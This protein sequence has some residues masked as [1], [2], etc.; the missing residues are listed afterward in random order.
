MAMPDMLFF[1]E[2][3]ENDNVL[4]IIA[5]GDTYESVE[6]ERAMLVEI[7]G[8]N[9]WIQTWQDGSNRGRYA[10]IGGRY[11]AENDVFID[12]KPDAFPSWVLQSDGSWAPPIAYPALIA[13]SEWP[14]E[15]GEYVINQ[16]YYWDENSV[17]WIL[18]RP[19][20]Q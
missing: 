1:A 18:F 9:C 19:Q 20:P 7:S 14:E 4:N 10:S 17:S 11:D 6:T 13:E 8:H 2:L 3:D 12:R 15:Y 5:C 16:K